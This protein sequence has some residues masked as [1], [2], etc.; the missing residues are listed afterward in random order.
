MGAW[1]S[2]INIYSDLKDNQLNLEVYTQGL[3]SF[4]F[5]FWSSQYFNKIQLWRL[6]LDQIEQK[7]KNGL[8]TLA[9]LFSS[10]I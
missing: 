9:K 5:C 1:D 2:N 7:H 6:H 8:K 4:P 3:K 10:I